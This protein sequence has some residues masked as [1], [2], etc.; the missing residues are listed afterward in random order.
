[1]LDCCATIY[2]IR[3]EFMNLTCLVPA[4]NE[5]GFLQ[6]VISQILSID[7]IK[8]IIIIEGGSVDKTYEEALKICGQNPE[9]IK[10]VKQIGKGKHD[11]VQTGAKIASNELIMI[12]DADG[13]VPLESTL[14][15][16]N[17]SI[18]YQRVTIGDRL[19]GSREE[20]S[21][22]FFNL[23][24]NWAFSI[25]W[26]P[27]LKT[28]PIDVLCGTKIFPAQVFNRVPKK[29]I[30]A[31][32]YGDFAL[33]ATSRLLGYTVDSIPVNYLSRRY[34]QTNIKRWSGGLSL[35]HT[36]FLAYFFLVLKRVKNVG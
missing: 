19:A 25:L 29:L 17:H 12:W 6:A 7:S 32:P 2:L 31:D 18:K 22:R 33:L 14:K 11:A 5:Q 20:N 10:V 28:K 36:T 1:M 16:I 9:R 27:I 23:L 4:R 26:S 13:T 35:L 24:G 34:G 21:M 30:R 3:R 8:E 15:V